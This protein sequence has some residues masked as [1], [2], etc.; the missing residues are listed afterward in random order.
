MAYEIV[1]ILLLA[2]ICFLLYKLYRIKYTERE[3]SELIPEGWKKDLMTL[4]NDKGR[5]LGLKF[6]GINSRISEIEKK[7]E[8]NGKVVERLVEELS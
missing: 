4:G 7:I 2:V 3:G 8:R 6:E 5:E 1:I